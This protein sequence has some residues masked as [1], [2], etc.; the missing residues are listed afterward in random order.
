[1][2]KV[3]GAGIYEL[4]QRSLIK[5]QSVEV[6]SVGLETDWGTTEKAA[7]FGYVKEDTPTI[8]LRVRENIQTGRL[9]MLVMPQLDD[10]FARY[11]PEKRDSPILIR[12]GGSDQQ[13]STDGSSCPVD[14]GASWSGNGCSG[15]PAEDCSCTESDYCSCWEPKVHCYY[16][17]DGSVCDCEIVDWR[18]GGCVTGDGGCCTTASCSELCQPHSQ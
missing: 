8:I 14:G 10:A 16:N 13:S 9:N 11:I 6:N 5:K 15:N 18:P 7:I 17:E 1:M 12:P 4:G 2:L 3:L